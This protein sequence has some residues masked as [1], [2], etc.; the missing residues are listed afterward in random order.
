MIGEDLLGTGG[1]EGDE[2]GQS[3]GHQV[4]VCRCV[5]RLRVP[6]KND[7]FLKVPSGQIGSK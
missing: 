2:V 6:A 5:Q 1:E 7:Q 3:Q 4:A